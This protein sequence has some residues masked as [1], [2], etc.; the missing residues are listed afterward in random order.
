MALWFHPLAVFVVIAGV[1]LAV[2]KPHLATQFRIMAG[3][4]D[5]RA[6]EISHMKSKMCHFLPP[7]AGAFLSFL[8]QKMYYAPFVYS[9]HVVYGALAQWLR[10]TCGDRQ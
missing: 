4:M 9:F 2:L 8:E 5:F 3:M 10:I 6:T 1:D 7:S